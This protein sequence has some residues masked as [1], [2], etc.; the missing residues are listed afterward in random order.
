MNGSNS[1]RNFKLEETNSVVLQNSSPNN[2]V[3]YITNIIN[4]SVQNNSSNSNTNSF[5]NNGS[6]G[7]MLSNNSLVNNLNLSSDLTNNVTTNHLGLLNNNNNYVNN[8]DN[9]SANSL[10]SGDSTITRGELLDQIENL[11]NVA[12]RSCLN[13]L[14]QEK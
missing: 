11:P 14:Y 12:M 10:V 3:E 8:I 1:N 4:N 9:L 13:K 7:N 6:N 5:V 2:S